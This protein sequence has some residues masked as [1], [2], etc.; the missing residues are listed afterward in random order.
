[1][2]TAYAVL[3]IDLMHCVNAVI[4][5]EDRVLKGMF[6]IR[7][8]KRRIDFARDFGRDAFARIGIRGDFDQAIEAMDYCRK[9]R[10]QYAHCVWWDDNTAQLA[11]R[12]VEELAQQEDPV[13]L[14]D[15]VPTHVNVELLSHQLRY[16]EYADACFI[17]LIRDS[18][19]RQ[20]LPFHPGVHRPDAF[21]RPALSI[22]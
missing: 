9:I 21:P 14:R 8:E 4:H 5:D 2:L 1:M 10:N 19:E 20:N 7:G 22:P 18:R 13:H 17:W 6:G 16:F 12:A 11:F 3:E 15:L